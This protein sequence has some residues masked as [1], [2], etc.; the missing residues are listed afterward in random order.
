[1]GLQIGLLSPVIPV[2]RDVFG[3]DGK[4]EIVAQ[5]D[6]AGNGFSSLGLLFTDGD[7]L[8]THPGLL[9]PENKPRRL[10]WYRLTFE[11]GQVTMRQDAT[12]ASGYKDPRV[13]RAPPLVVSTTPVDGLL[14]LVHHIGLQFGV[15]ARLDTCTGARGRKLDLRRSVL[16]ERRRYS[17]E[18][19]ALCG[20]CYDE[21]AAQD[22]H[23]RDERTVIDGRR[24]LPHA[25]LQI[26]AK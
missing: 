19:D 24:I 5:V 18:V 1:M 7:Q 23:L 10:T 16:A 21:L 12:R 25:A 22:A 2:T 13:L 17:G 15:C 4:G 26:L 8:W 11:D 9:T 20:H 14:M 6:G 3:P